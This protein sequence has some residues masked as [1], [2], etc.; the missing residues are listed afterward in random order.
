MN[1]APPPHRE[2]T[3]AAAAKGLVRGGPEGM[4]GGIASNAD[5]GPQ[6]P[7]RR[8]ER[9]AVR[10]GESRGKADVGKV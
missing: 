7:A 1:K 6:T 9:E 10:E 3:A 4:G 2:G 5:G 8:P